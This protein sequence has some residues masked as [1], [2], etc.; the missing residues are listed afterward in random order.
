[1]GRMAKSGRLEIQV[2]LDH[3]VNQDPEEYKEHPE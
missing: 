1:M 3:P 2:K